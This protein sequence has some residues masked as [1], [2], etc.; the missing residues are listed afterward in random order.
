M[1]QVSWSA[2]PAWSNN[3]K[4]AARDWNNNCMNIATTVR[5]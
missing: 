4:R 5:N 3:Y 1:M 2:A